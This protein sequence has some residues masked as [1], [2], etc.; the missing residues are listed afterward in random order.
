[1]QSLLRRGA[2]AQ[3]SYCVWG[4][5]TKKSGGASAP[6]CMGLL[7]AMSCILDAIEIAATRPER[8]VGKSQGK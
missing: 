3:T 8:V 1:L 2:A 5:F 6:Y 7:G 4:C